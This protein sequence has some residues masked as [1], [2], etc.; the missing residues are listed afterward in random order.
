MPKSSARSRIVT[1]EGPGR[2]RHGLEGNHSVAVAAQVSC[3]ACGCG[4]LVRKTAHLPAGTSMTSRSS[5]AGVS[6]TR[7]IPCR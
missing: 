7:A 2:S 3:R 1:I 4:P 6:R 5:G